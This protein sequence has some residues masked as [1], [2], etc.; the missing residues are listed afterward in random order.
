MQVL[1]I[2]GGTIWNFFFRLSLFCKISLLT[3]TK[4]MGMKIVHEYIIH[5]QGKLGPFG[6]T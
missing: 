3:E 1:R 4:F 2:H 5:E 6:E